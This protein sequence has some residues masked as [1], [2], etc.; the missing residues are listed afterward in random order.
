M[1]PRLKIP[2]SS[3]AMNHALFAIRAVLSSAPIHD[4]RPAMKPAS[5]VAAPT[6]PRPTRATPSGLPLRPTMSGPSITN[7]SFA[8]AIHTAA[9]ARMAPARTASMPPMKNLVTVAL[10]M[11]IVSLSLGMVVAGSAIAVQT[12]MATLPRA[13]PSP[14]WSIARSASP[15]G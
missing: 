10:D 12:V 8:M 15:S 4:T 1:N 13:C 14:T 11:S 9:T 2:V 3:R 5:I 6:I 7:T